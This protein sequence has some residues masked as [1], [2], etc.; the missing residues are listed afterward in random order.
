MAESHKVVIIVRIDKSVQFTQQILCLQDAF[1]LFQLIA[2]AVAIE[3]LLQ[4]LLPQSQNQTLTDHHTH[5]LRANI[6]RLYF[7][8]HENIY[9]LI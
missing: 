5:F 1:W 4:T 6:V 9:K 2:V 8:Y 3:I 7:H